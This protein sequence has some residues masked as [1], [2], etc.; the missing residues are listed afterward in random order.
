MAVSKVR[1]L[2]I[3]AHGECRDKLLKELRRLGTVH[4]SDIKEISPESEGQLP[5]FLETSISQ[6]EAKIAQINHCLEF[7]AAFL[8]KPPLAQS[9]F[10]GRPVFAQREV[11]EILS[12]FDLDK[13]SNEWSSIEKE[14]NENEAQIAKKEVLIEDI[15]HWLH[16]DSPLESIQDTRHTR[17]SLGICDAR[18][19]PAMTEELAN[20]SPLH[21]IEVVELS[22]S[23]VSMILFYAKDLEETFTAVVRKYGWRSVQFAGLT[24]TPAEITARL[25]EQIRELRE[26]NQQMREYV[27]RQCAP[28]HDKLLLLHDH[29]SQELRTLQVQ[30]RFL[31]TSR[32]FAINGWIPA[33]QEGRLKKRLHEL[34]Q[35]IEIRF[36]DPQPG[37]VVPIL[38]KNRPAIKPFSLI[39]ELYGRPQYTEFDPTP[40]LAPFFAFFF[41]ICIGDAGYGIVL[42]A[43][44]LIALKKFHIQGGA[45]LLLQILAWGGL[46]SFIIGILTGGIFAIPSSKLPWFV[47]KFLVFEPSKQVLAFLYITFIIGLAQ[48]IF[49]LILKMIMS[50]RD[51]DYIGGISDQ[52]LWML[53]LV[54]I[55]PLFYKYLFGGAASDRVITIARTGALIL[56]GPL[57]LGRGRQNKFYFIPLMGLLNVARDTLG[58]FGDT[59]S[60]ARLMALG[61]SGAFLAMTIND[62]ASLVLA[63]PYGIGFVLA[64]IIAVFGHTFNIVISS[65]GAFV[66]SLRLQYL[67]FF[68]KFFTGGGRPFEPFA[69][70]REHTVIRSD[71]G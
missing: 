29:Y 18:L 34:T 50:F 61:L 48:I 31:F 27:A 70:V 3:L 37:D 2:E 22:R 43:V 56:I 63:I 21:H 24:G 66:H 51:G 52:F 60:Y 20:A 62:I 11:D 44:S 12:T 26:R 40:F 46:S 33:N 64:V 25:R 36:F 5:S 15:S 10:Q 67:E 8:P 32:T 42:M 14:L 28:V 55:A 17:I 4:I 49:G 39:T 19:Y 6:T 9:L 65:L 23:S 1:K 30:K 16:L 38:L 57:V 71:A 68:G 7:G 13:F 41:G 35:D 45:R 53:M 59:L 47:N 69:E 58:F 54:C